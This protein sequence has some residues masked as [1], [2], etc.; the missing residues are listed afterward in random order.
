MFLL[1]V[2]YQWSD[3]DG[4]DC[5]SLLRRARPGQL[6]R[7]L[8]D[9]QLY[10]LE[11]DLAPADHGGLLKNL[12][13]YGWF[14]MGAPGFDST[15]TNRRDWLKDVKD[16]IDDL[17]AS[18]TSPLAD[19]REAVRSAVD[20][21]AAFGCSEVI[22]P[23]PLL[24]DPEDNLDNYF[25]LLDDAVEVAS[26]R[27]QLPLLASIP[28]DERFLAH[29]TPGGSPVVEALADGLTVRDRLAGVYMTLSTEASSSVLVINPRVVGSLLRL[30]SL[31]GR[32]AGLLVVTNFVESLG[33]A[34]LGFGGT[35]YGS[36]FSVKSRCLRVSDYVDRGGGAAYPKFNSVALG[37]E[38]SPEPDLER[39]RDAKLLRYLKNDGTP[40]GQP[41]LDA[42]A[43][44]Q[45][46]ASVPAW[47]RRRN[48]VAAARLHYAQNH[49]AW[50]KRSWDAGAIQ[51]WLQDAEAS[52]SYISQRF[53][54]APLSEADGRHLGPW[55]RAVDELTA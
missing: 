15:E 4:Q 5:A 22:L 32:D 40:A 48:N 3:L 8:F 29:R 41:V 19:W 1:N 6:A 42:L 49:V 52:W 13:T 50:A 18:R 53:E 47:E 12:A 26:P 25:A 37:L 17:W 2:G 27:T 7:V 35:A 44:R 24:A 54:D 30:S 33:L 9:P 23:S 39:L 28:M 45:D 10:L 51:A 14:G 16:S 34:S 11:Y 43:N 38:F 20:V 36:G 21:Q 46:T 31:I 55:R